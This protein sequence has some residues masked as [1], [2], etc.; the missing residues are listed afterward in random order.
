VGAHAIVHALP[1]RTRILST[2][3]MRDPPL[4]TVSHLPVRCAHSPSIAPPHTPTRNPR[5]T[6]RRSKN[7]C[8]IASMQAS[9]GSGHMLKMEMDNEQALLS[10]DV[11]NFFNRVVDQVGSGESVD[12]YNDLQGSDAQDMHTP[13]DDDTEDD[14]D[15]D[16]DTASVS[17]SG[18]RRHSSSS[19]G[20]AGKLT[21]R[22]R[23][24][25]S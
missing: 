19:S 16:D 7:L 4:L 12:A 3:S 2:P 24:R 21:P 1:S 14:D 23:K 10:S 5:E 25:V 18:V 11:L 17:S 20:S 8:N 13:H 15:D 22:R 9:H 6:S